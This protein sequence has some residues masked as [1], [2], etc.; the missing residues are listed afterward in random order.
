MRHFTTPQYWKFYGA[1]TKPVRQSADKA[2]ALLKENP[3]HPSLRFERKGK[4]WSVRISG[5]YRALAK[6]RPEGLLWVW[7]GAHDEYER[8]IGSL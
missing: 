1:L 3:S 2:F 4:G 5:G 8:L 6:E 7:I